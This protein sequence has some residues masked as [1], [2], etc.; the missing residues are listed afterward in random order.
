[1]RQGTKTTNF[2]AIKKAAVHAKRM[3][4]VDLH[5]ADTGALV[6]YR[7]GEGRKPW[8]GTMFL[9]NYPVVRIIHD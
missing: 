7:P 8:D 9:V 5:L 1:M 4:M 6:G 3:G 2:G